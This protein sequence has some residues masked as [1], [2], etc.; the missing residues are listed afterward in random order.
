M[1]EVILDIIGSILDAII[2]IDWLNDCK[3]KDK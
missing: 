1:L 2:C 3:R